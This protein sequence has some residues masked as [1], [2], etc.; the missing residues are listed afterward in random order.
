MVKHLKVCGGISCRGKGSENLMGQ[1]K[2]DLNLVEGGCN[3]NFCLDYC[4]CTAHCEQGINIRVGD[5]IAHGVT[6]EN[7]REKIA[8][9]EEI[10][11]Q[12]IALDVKDNF[13]NDI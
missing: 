2:S 5:K 10:K 12:E 13:L 7:W 9:P 11:I 8:K 4:A 3:E 1:I 6:I